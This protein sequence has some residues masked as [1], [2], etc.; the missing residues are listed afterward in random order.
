MHQNFEAMTGLNY[1]F[2]RNL[3]ACVFS[4]YKTGIITT[5]NDFTMCRGATGR[6]CKKVAQHFALVNISFSKNLVYL[7]HAE[8]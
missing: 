4:T 8:F 5:L 3:Y 1:R 6:Y 7:A 2:I